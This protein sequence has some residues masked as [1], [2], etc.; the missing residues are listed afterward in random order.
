VVLS[1]WPASR[2][3]ATDRLPMPLS[4]QPTASFCRPIHSS[5]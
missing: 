4:T 2:S 3:R 5:S 1:W